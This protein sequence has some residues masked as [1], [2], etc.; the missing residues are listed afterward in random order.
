MKKALP[1]DTLQHIAPT[2]SKKQES[3]DCELSCQV[4]TD[5]NNV[6]M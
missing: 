2:T 3:T 1:C 6:V 4:N 5:Q